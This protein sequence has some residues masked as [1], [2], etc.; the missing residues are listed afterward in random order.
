M[1][2]PVLIL[3]YNGS[4]LLAECLPSILRAAA[5]SRHQAVVAIIDNGSTDDSRALLADQFP[6]VTVFDRPNLGLTSFNSV[7]AE[8]EGDVALLLNNDVKL[9]PDSIDRLVDPLLASRDGCFLTAPQCRRFDEVSYEGLKTAIGWKW[10][11]VQATCFYRGHASAT[12]LPGWTACAG[13]VMAVDRRK[14]LELGGFDP[15]YLPGRLEDLDLAYRAWLAGYHAEYIPQ[16]LAYHYGAATF[17]DVFGQQGCDELALRNTLLFI[18]KNL[19]HP[20][21]LTR[22]WVGLTVRLLCEPAR[23]AVSPAAERWMLVRAIDA[24][25]RRRRQMTDR[26]YRAEFDYRDLTREWNWFRRFHARAID[27]EARR[28]ERRAR[29]LPAQGK[30]ALQM[31]K[32]ET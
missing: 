10:G 5:A 31:A 26:A 32:A 6:G 17:G 29:A 30:L 15:L 25:I 4:R 23:A 16:A 12:E 1:P 22:H 20:W 14:F 28:A 19:R 21:H 27:A 18:W 3:N 24:A 8:Q 7:L 13:P 2:V 11:L 9:A